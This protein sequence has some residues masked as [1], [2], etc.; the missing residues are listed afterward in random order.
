M[1]LYIHQ[2]APPKIHIRVIRTWSLPALTKTAKQPAAYGIARPASSRSVATSA[3][4]W[5]VRCND[6]SGIAPA[7]HVHQRKVPSHQ[8]RAC[9]S[10][11]AMLTGQCSRSPASVYLAVAPT[12]ASFVKLRSH[13]YSASVALLSLPTSSGVMLSLTSRRTALNTFSATCSTCTH[14]YEAAHRGSSMCAYGCFN[15]TVC[16]GA[17]GQ[18]MS[19][20][21]YC[22]QLP[23]PLLRV[24]TSTHTHTHL[25]WLELDESFDESVLCE[26]SHGT[27]VVHLILG[28]T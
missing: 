26:H 23:E 24:T 27:P 25:R 3:C 6:A 5:H 14:T 18:G 22:R 7:A 10:C 15:K 19:V 20:F 16:S 1:Q 9:L 21:T 2:H 13:L 28:M 11:V 8:G 4:T 17:A 12:L